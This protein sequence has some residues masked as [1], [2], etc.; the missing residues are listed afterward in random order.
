MLYYTSDDAVAFITPTEWQ[1]CKGVSLP[2]PQY[3]DAVPTIN[4]FEIPF[5]RNIQVHRSALLYFRRLQLRAISAE[6]Q[7]H[8][9]ETAVTTCESTWI[10]KTLLLNLKKVIIIG[11]SIRL[12]ERRNVCVT[13][14]GMQSLKCLI[15]QI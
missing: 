8:G 11:D 12:E 7:D 14:T 3:Y 9:A 5:Y 2:F 15:A 1:S 10:S 13:I 6:H 4:T